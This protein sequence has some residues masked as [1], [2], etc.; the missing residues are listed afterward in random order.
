MQLKAQEPAGCS[1]LLKQRRRSWTTGLCH[2]RQCSLLLLGQLVFRK[3][4]CLVKKLLV[5]GQQWWLAML[6]NKL[7]VFK[8]QW[9][10]VML[11]R[12]LLVFSKQ[13]WL[14][15]LVNKLLVFSRQWWLVMLLSKLWALVLGKVPLVLLGL[16]RNNLDYSTG[17][18]RLS[19]MVLPSKLSQQAQQGL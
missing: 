9:W 1:L 5:L 3:Q 15:M 6:A 4:W 2:N 19:S 8:K 14:A 18:H 13:W 12:K 16:G 10:L 11:V 17:H 7:L